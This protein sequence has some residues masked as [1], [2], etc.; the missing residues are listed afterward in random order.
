MARLPILPA[1]E[2]VKGLVRAGF[3]VVSQ[4]GSHLKLSGLRQGRV[5]AVIVPLYPELPRGLLASILRQA[6]MTREEFLALLE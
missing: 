4:R 6:G 5:L 3:Q 2:V 1:R